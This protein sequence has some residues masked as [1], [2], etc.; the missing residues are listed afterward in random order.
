[1]KLSAKKTEDM[2]SDEVVSEWRFAAMVSFLKYGILY[3][4]VF[5]DSVFYTIFFSH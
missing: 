2:E 4:G 5:K 1:M 3:T